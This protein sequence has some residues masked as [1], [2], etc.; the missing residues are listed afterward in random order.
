MKIDIKETISQ[1]IL[2]KSTL[3]FDFNENFN[4]FF[5]FTSFKF[6]TYNNSVKI[7]FEIAIFTKN[8]HDVYQIFSKPVMFQNS[9]YIL[10]SNFSFLING[11]R[12]M[13]LFNNETFNEFCPWISESRFCQI[14]KNSGGRGQPL[15]VSHFF[16]RGVRGKFFVRLP[17]QNI[18]TKIGDNFYFTVFSPFE[19]HVICGNT[20]YSVRVT[21]SSKIE[22]NTECALKTS[23]FEH[24]PIDRDNEYHL[25]IAKLYNDS[26]E[27][28]EVGERGESTMLTTDIIIFLLVCF[29][30]L[31]IIT[32]LLY[33]LQ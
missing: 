1:E 15:V 17:R 14:S 22:N 27:T 25:H 8:K 10:R 29:A 6:G 19:L 13:I 4:Q 7:S 16:P 32:M 21:K 12:K 26:E 23:F 33:K 24:Q 30:V 20:N 5:E 3:Q 18:V 9:P 11:T 2:N 28:A 31:V